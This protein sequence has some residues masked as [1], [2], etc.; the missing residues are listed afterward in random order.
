MKQGKKK[1]SIFDRI[2][3][4]VLWWNFGDVGIAVLGRNFDVG[5]GKPA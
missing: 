1:L 5:T 3:I 4:F 2:L